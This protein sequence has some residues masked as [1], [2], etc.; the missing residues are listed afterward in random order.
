[1]LDCYSSFFFKK[2]IIGYYKNKNVSYI[3]SNSPNVLIMNM[4]SFAGE[5]I[6]R[7]NS[8]LA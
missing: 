6:H 3:I 8:V 5:F 2:Q 4:Q 1:M 7:M